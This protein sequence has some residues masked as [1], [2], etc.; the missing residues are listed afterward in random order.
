MKNQI[1]LTEQDK[2]KLNRLNKRSK[3]AVAIF[4]G[5]TVVA[6]VVVVGGFYFTPAAV[7]PSIA[8]LFVA[9]FAFGCFMSWRESAKID[10]DIENGIKERIIGVV[11]KKTISRGNQMLTYDADT[12]AM[13]AVR[14]EEQELNKPITRYGILDRE[15]DSAANYWYGVEIG[16]ANYNIGVRNWIG[17]KEGETLT[18][19][20][21]PKSRRVISFVK[22]GTASPLNN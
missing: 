17:V 9:M 16:T 22:I 5:V 6:A 15:I 1:A 4:A 11:L 7:W 3:R 13:V 20:V 14:V 12:L 21:A 18:L 10:R 8:I 2:Q 19:E